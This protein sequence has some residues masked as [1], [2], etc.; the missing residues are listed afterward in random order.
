MVIEIDMRVEFLPN[1][2]LVRP[3]ADVSRVVQQVGD[4]TDL[5]HQREEVGRTDEVVGFLIRVAQL[6]DVLEGGLLPQL[7]GLVDRATFFKRREVANQAAREVVGEEAVDDEVWKRFRRA[8]RLS[9]RAGVGRDLGLNQRVSPRITRRRRG[10]GWR[11]RH[12]RQ[13]ALGV[14]G[15]CRRSVGSQ[16]GGDKVQVHSLNVVDG[17]VTFVNH[18]AVVD[19]HGLA[20]GIV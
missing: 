18:D 8:K 20:S 5:A 17:D 11:S 13:S 4:P 14:Q 6:T 10:R 15:R 12:R 2:V 19:G 1:T 7:T 3:A 9:E 16:P